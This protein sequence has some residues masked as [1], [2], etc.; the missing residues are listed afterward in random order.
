[1]DMKKNPPVEQTVFGSG[2][3][4]VI[5]PVVLMCVFIYLFSF[6]SPPPSSLLSFYFILCIVVELEGGTHKKH[7]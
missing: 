7:G 3:L 6:L 2:D 5:K 1:M 4:H